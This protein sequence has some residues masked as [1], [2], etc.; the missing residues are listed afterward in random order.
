MNN[1]FGVPAHPLLVH[2]PVVG[3]PVLAMLAV[4][5]IVKPEWREKLAVPT[6]VLA[7]LMAA[8]TILAAGAGESLQERVPNTELVRKHA[9]LGDQLKAITIA[10]AAVLVAYAV[11]LKFKSHDLL[12]RLAPLLP[13]LLAGC[14]LVGAVAT[15]W[16]VRTGHAGAKAVWNQT[17]GSSSVVSTEPLTS[18]AAEVDGGSKINSER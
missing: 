12:R 9:E 15:V 2:L 4:A 10:F 18:S 6:A 1:L 14:V 17:P 8:A 5:M 7:V 3:I 13:A 11:L 16:D